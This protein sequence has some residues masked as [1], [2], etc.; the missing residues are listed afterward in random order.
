MLNFNELNKLNKKRSELKLEPYNKILEMICSKIVEASTILNQQYC[1]Y[2]VP[3]VIFGYSLYEI[4]D[5]CNWLKKKLLKKGISSVD[6]LE[7]NILVIKWN[8]N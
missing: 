2:Q 8:Y 1:V 4:S 6:I 5:C 3:E 7:Q